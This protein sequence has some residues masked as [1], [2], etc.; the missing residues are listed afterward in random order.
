MTYL[1]F[2]TRLSLLV[3]FA[4][5]LVGKTHN[6]SAWASFVA[7]TKS[8]LGVRRAAEGW[9]A[10]VVLI[11]AGTVGCL[12]LNET[13]YAGLVFALLG[14]TAFLAVVLNGVRRG[15]ETS[16]NC[17]GSDGTTLGWPHI[18]RNV[19]LVGVAALGV[20]AASNS[21]IPSMFPTATYATPMV[22]GLIAAALFVVWDDV[23]YLVVGQARQRMTN[24]ER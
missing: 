13:A 17:F 15:V 10:A 6:R 24:S 20:A 22:L 12:L 1:I 23:T 4:S 18:W 16:C 8:L 21:R 14:L 3:V 11:E 7:A 19:L 2:F 5:A 9:S